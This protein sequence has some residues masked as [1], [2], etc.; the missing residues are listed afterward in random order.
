MNGHTG[1]VTVT[2]DITH[3]TT[4]RVA[5]R[6]S[7]GLAALLLAVT[8]AA[9]SGWIAYL[10][11]A[12]D[13]MYGWHTLLLVYTVPVVTVAATVWSGWWLRDHGR[14]WWWVTAAV[15]A[16]TAWSVATAAVGFMAGEAV[17]T[18]VV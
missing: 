10:E 8:Q 18:A 1:T 6:R 16:A 7:A 5:L 11:R 9:F 14:S 15:V 2:D 17:A 3:D 12:V 4:R 13:P